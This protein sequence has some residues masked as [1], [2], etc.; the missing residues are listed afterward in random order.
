MKRFSDPLAPWKIFTTEHT[1]TTELDP[2]EKMNHTGACS[3]FSVVQKR[4][5]RVWSGR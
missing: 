1:E 4:R 3:V 2:E 5:D